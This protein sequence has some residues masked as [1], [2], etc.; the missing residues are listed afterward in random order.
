NS[1]HYKSPIEGKYRGRGVANGYWNNWGGKSSA[2]AVLNADGTVSLNEA[3]TDIGGS[4]ASIAMQFAEEAG[5]AY[6]HVKPRVGDTDSVSYN[7]VTGGSRTTFGTGW[8][9]IEL[10]RLMIAEMKKR[11]SDIWGVD[12]VS[13]EG[14][15][16][17]GGDNKA[18]WDQ[19]A[20]MINSGEK[21]LMVSTTVHPQGFGPGFST[22]CVDVEVDP[23]T[24]KVQI[25]RYTAVQDVG[26]AIHPSYVEGQ[27]QGGVVQGIGWGLNEEYV[28]NDK[29]QLLNASLLDYRMPTAYDLPEIETVLVEVANPDH[30]YGVRGV[31]EV[32][33]VPPAAAI[34]NAIYQ[35]TGLRMTRLPMSP[36]AMLEAMWEREGLATGD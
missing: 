8:A 33:I 11:L 34:A 6:D 32:P 15:V 23:E 4:R 24:G 17:S 28:Y 36:A 31:G 2:D 25:L 14:S 22:Q 1:D 9:V 18:T 12:E 26:K 10:A 19:A 35:A 3:S 7:D 5:I 27:I 16:F 13:Y 29:G 30:P 20:K 21:P